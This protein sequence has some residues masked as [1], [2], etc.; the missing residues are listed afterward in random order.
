VCRFI[1]EQYAPFNGKVFGCGL[2]LI[3]ST[4]VATPDKGFGDLGGCFVSLHPTRDDSRITRDT[5][6]ELRPR[7]GGAAVDALDYSAYATTDKVP[8]MPAGGAVEF[9]VDYAAN[10]VRVAFYMPAAVAAGFTGEVG[11]PFA[12]MEFRFN[13]PLSAD[14]LWGAAV[15]QGLEGSHCGETAPTYCTLQMQIPPPSSC[16]RR[17]YYST[18][19]FAKMMLAPSGDSG[20]FFCC[21]CCCLFFLHFGVSSA[22]RF[23]FVL[24]VRCCKPSFLAILVFFPGVANHF[25][26]VL[27]EKICFPQRVQNILCFTPGIFCF[28]SLFAARS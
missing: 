24:P 17:G 1:V 5:W 22:T 10:A 2:G 19:G 12:K 25:F 7:Q 3:P 28:L 15:E 11:A 8:S 4:A 9:A 26:R 13:N 27:Q 21:C 14:V 20:P 6:T 16:L 23:N 18:H